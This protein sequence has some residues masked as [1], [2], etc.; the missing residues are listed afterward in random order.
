M[1]R[2]V[3]RSPLWRRE[4][5]HSCEDRLRKCKLPPGTGR[6][7]SD[8]RTGMTIDR[9]AQ[10]SRTMPYASIIVSVNAV[11]PVIMYKKQ[12]LALAAS[13]VLRDILSRGRLTMGRQAVPTLARRGSQ[14]NV[15]S[16]MPTESTAAVLQPNIAARKP[17]Q[18]CRASPAVTPNAKPMNATFP[19]R[20]TIAATRVRTV[21]AMDQ[22]TTPARHR[23]APTP[24]ARRPAARSAKLAAVG[25]P[26]HVAATQRS[27]PNAHS[28]DP[29][30]AV[31][32]APRR[33]IMRQARAPAHAPASRGSTLAST[34]LAPPNPSFWWMAT[35]VTAKGMPKARQAQKTVPVGRKYRIRRAW[36]RVLASLPA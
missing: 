31:W 12:L 1:H 28:A 8:S 19:T 36:K 11:P 18:S 29:P 9:K 6:L 21:S 26:R 7:E 32:R 13:H 20:T 33:S 14:A 23:L 25:L 15:P 30:M 27:A 5:Y 3:G 2:P 16:I 24:I 17:R 10:G 34:A 22:E 35:G 4:K